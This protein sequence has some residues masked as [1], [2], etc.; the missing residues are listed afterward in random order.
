ML[1]ATDEG[2]RVRLIWLL[3]FRAIVVTVLLVTATVLRVS[4]N[5][6]SF[7]RASTSIYVAAGLAYVTIA[8]GAAW[9]RFGPRSSAVPAAYVQLVADA[10]IATSLVWMTGG[11]ESIFVFLYSL[12]VLNAAIVLERRGAVAVA[13]VAALLYAS[14]LLSQFRGTHSP[15]WSLLP[16]F[17]TNAGS[18]FLVA[19]LGGYLTAQLSRTS[20]RLQDAR[21]AIERLEELYAAVLGSLPSGVMGVDDDGRVA[22]VNAAGADIL[23][24]RDL[25]GR[26]LGDRAPEL[27]R[28]AREPRDRFEL[29]VKLPQQRGPRFIGGSVAP[30]VGQDGK[31]ASG[32]VVVFQ[33]LT[34]LRRLQQEVARA[35]RLAELGRLAAGLAHEV[36]NPLAAMIGSLQLLQLDAPKLGDDGGRLLGIVQREAERLSRLVEAFLTFARPGPPERKTVALRPFLVELVG[37]ASNGAKAVDLVVGDVDVDAVAFCDPNQLRQILWNLLANADAII[38]S[39]GRRGRVDVTAAVD[40]DAVVVVVDDD[41]P[42]IAPELRERVFEPFF[43]TR[44]DG[45]GLGLATCAQLA[46]QNAAHI[47]VE[48]SPAG[49]ARFILRLARPVADVREGDG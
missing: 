38:S 32:T 46:R 44:S 24:V 9:V 17:L 1:P 11:V 18:L 19:L 10:L 31:G 6:P 26:P 5:E 4:A 28:L 15:M 45:N 49:G 47:S 33:D 21:A 48:G 20:E 16:S 29:E 27:L 34:E 13:A 14:V 25:A 41:G 30:L 35:E 2:V 36:R 43:T 12:T 39:L 8:I 42:G 7:E 40:G 23:G 3:V 37:A 22:Y